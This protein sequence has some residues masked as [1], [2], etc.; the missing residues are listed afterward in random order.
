MTNGATEELVNLRADEI[1]RRVLHPFADNEFA[2]HVSSIS[3]LVNGTI[4]RTGANKIVNVQGYKAAVGTSETTI[5]GVTA[6]RPIAAYRLY[7]VSDSNDDITTGSGARRVEIDGVDI[8][9]NEITDYCYTNAANPSDLTVKSFWRV[10]QVRVCCV[11]YY[12]GSN[13]GNI[14]VKIEGAGTTIAVIQKNGS[15]AFGRNTDGTFTVPAGYTAQVIGGN[16]FVDGNQAATI[17]MYSNEFANDSTASYQGAKTVQFIA[18]EVTGPVSV[19][20]KEPVLLPEFTDI[21]FSGYTGSSTSGVYINMIIALYENGRYIAK[22]QT[23]V[24]PY[25]FSVV[26]EDNNAALS[27][28]AMFAADT[29]RIYYSDTAGV[30]ESDS[31]VETT[32][33]SYDF[34]VQNG[35]TKYFAIQGVNDSNVSKGKLSREFPVYAHANPSAYAVDFGGTNEHLLESVGTTTGLLNGGTE[36]TFAAWVKRDT[37]SIYGQVFDMFDAKI[38]ML[39]LNNNKIRIYARPGTGG[40]APGTDTTLTYT[41]TDWYFVV[42]TWDLDAQYQR[43][44]VNG[45]LA[46]EANV[47]YSTQVWD[48]RTGSAYFGINNNGSSFPFD[49]KIDHAG[50]WT[51]RLLEREI[52][53][54]YNAGRPTNY[55]QSL[56]YYT[57]TSD[58]V[59]YWKIGDG[60]TY[61]TIQDSQ[62][63]AD[64]T[65][66]NMAASD[67]IASGY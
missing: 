6:W 29:Y 60:D 2:V 3:E 62:G 9:G 14:S 55:T 13:A 64:F 12:D 54:L 11:G 34:P 35:T 7:V 17:I 4:Q 59:G 45:E 39:W 28:S 10:N 44:Y 51:T 56:G 31:Y 15:V 67:I 32:S 37:D 25:D 49:G 33:T 27:W 58:L 65:M 23:P 36:A 63:S 43:I 61:P 8:N 16:G 66:T 22:Y 21:T 40:A 50:L 20:F 52:L 41:G 1:A 38:G 57:Q 5:G 47:A 42:G 48:T 53:S 26:A 30:T 19:E 46:V 24:M 18:P